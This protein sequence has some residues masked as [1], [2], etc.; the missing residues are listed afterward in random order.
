[1]EPAPKPPL[2]LRYSC[3]VTAQA[4]LLFL[5]VLLLL[6]M[7]QRVAAMASELDLAIPLIT[8][9]FVSSPL[10]TLL[11]FIGLMISTIIFA[12][13]H[14]KGAILASVALLMQGIALGLYLLAILLPW[15]K[16][17]DG[18]MQ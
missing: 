1:M 15:M 2:D 4:I 7:L 17:W 3:L 6:G 11:S 10:V 13:C 18:I 9:L 5:P 14:R 8:R 16:M 12:W